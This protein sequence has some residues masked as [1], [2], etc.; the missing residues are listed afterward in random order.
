MYIYTFKTYIYI[1]IFFFLSLLTIELVHVY[2]ISQL[3]WNKTSIW[4]FR[5]LILYPLW[6]KPP[7]PNDDITQR[8]RVDLQHNLVNLFLKGCFGMCTHVSCMCAN[9]SCMRMHV[10]FQDFALHLS[11]MSIKSPKGSFPKWRWIH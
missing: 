5:Q 3:S 11:M 7:F 2:F 8:V 4:Y 1:Y 10:E 6:P 9:T